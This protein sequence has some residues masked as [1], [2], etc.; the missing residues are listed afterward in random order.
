MRVLGIQ[1][2]PQQSVTVLERSQELVLPRKARE[3]RQKT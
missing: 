1:L 2:V 3:G